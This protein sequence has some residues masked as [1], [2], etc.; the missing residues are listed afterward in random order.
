MSADIENTT[1]GPAFGVGPLSRAG[2][3]TG[4]M[5]D[6]ISVE[7]RSRNMSRIRSR[8]TKPEL[9][10]RQIVHGMGY[11]FRLHR[12]DLPGKP[13]IVLPRLGKVILVHGC[14]WHRHTCKEG[15]RRPKSRTEY[16][17]PKIDANVARDRRARRR[18][19]RLGW[20]VLVVWECQIA[21]TPDFSE[22]IYHFLES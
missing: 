9:V 12:H 5:A 13:D 4:V 20:D 15:R 10:V 21:M 8:N 17:I 1:S 6:R 19:R 18:L 11:R 2:I 7:R 16:W 14:F 3:L 22:R